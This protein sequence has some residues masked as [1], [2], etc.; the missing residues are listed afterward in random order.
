M[1]KNIGITELH[2]YL[3]PIAEVQIT[4]EG[5]S[6]NVVVPKPVDILQIDNALAHAIHAEP[7]DRF[8]RPDSWRIRLMEREKGRPVDLHYQA[9]RVIDSYYEYHPITAER[10]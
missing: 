8:E 4:E 3:D 2:K 5:G 6:M 9:V 7:L 10:S 1:G